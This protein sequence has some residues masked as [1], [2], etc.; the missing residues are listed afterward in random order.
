[1]D[2]FLTIAQ[3]NA[4]RIITVAQELWQVTEEMNMDI[5]RI[6]EPHPIVGGRRTAG[7][8]DCNSGG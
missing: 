8:S 7:V 5:F 4:M 2:K 6:Q 1:M 3:I